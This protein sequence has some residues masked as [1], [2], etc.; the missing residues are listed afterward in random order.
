MPP[1]E[2]H[3]PYQGEGEGSKNVFGC[4][5]VRIEAE[6]FSLCKIIKEIKIACVGMGECF[7]SLK[8]SVKGQLN[9]I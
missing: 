4:K 1:L 8:Q 9:R 6:L 7:R 5:I 3:V 2:G